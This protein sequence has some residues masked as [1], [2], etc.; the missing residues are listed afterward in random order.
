MQILEY[1]ISEQ[2]YSY[3]YKFEKENRTIVKKNV[4]EFFSKKSNFKI[5]L[6]K[7]SM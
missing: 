6:N 7:I 1:S 3:T 4:S 2:R 5:F